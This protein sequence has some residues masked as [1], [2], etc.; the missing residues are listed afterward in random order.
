[1]YCTALGGGREGRWRA[2]QERRGRGSK[3]RRRQG[4]RR[5]G[6]SERNPS[7]ASLRKMLAALERFWNC[8]VGC[9]S[10]LTPPNSQASSGLEHTIQPPPS[11][12]DQP[13]WSSPLTSH[14]PSFCFY[15]C[16][17]PSGNPISSSTR[18]FLSL[19]SPHG[20]LAVP[21]QVLVA[22]KT[23]APSSYLPSCRF[24]S[25]PFSSHHFLLCQPLPGLSS[26]LSGPL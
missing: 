5:R 10:Y 25:P 14:L 26:P 23:P 12:S 11:S 17:I 22:P 9:N 18:R 16:S 8:S 19:F 13:P 6:R 15:F 24:S 2:E 7:H 1:M 3:W 4:P 20:H 21:W